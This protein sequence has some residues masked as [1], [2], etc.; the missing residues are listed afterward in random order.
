[1]RPTF[2][3]APRRQIEATAALGRVSALRARGDL[4]DA[5]RE[6]GDGGR[7]GG[8][9]ARPD[10]GDA[11]HHQGGDRSAHVVRNQFD[12]GGAARTDVL[13]QQSEVAT[14]QAT[15]PPLQKQLEQQHH[16]PAGADRPLSERGAGAI[17]DLAALRLPTASAG[18][19]AL[20][21]G[22]AAAG[23][24]RRGSAIASGQRPDRRRHRRAA[25]AIQ[26]H[27]AI[28]AAPR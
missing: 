23:R 11:G 1:M 22:R 12:V 16:R 5:H 15:L 7:S 9:A 4:S 6:R 17:A 27:A 28:M 2:S 8:F 24:A 21:T 26:S 10:R 25:A 19:P 20:A 3:A 18:Q 14:A 13:T